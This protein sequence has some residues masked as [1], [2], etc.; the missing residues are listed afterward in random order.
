MQ[1]PSRL[2]D[3]FYGLQ[4]QEPSYRS[5]FPSDFPFDPGTTSSLFELNYFPSTASRL[6]LLIP[7]GVLLLL[8]VYRKYIQQ[9][10]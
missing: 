1:Y 4:K 7:L 3:V 5:D 9:N 8:L 10:I 6:L 2:E